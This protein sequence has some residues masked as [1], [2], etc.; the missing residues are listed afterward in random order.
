LVA[1][2]AAIFLDGKLAA[3]APVYPLTILY[4]NTIKFAKR[5]CVDVVPEQ[6]ELTPHQYEQ[7]FNVERVLKKD[8]R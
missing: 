4:G 5:T 8:G 2:Y 7:A 1:D 3:I 6:V